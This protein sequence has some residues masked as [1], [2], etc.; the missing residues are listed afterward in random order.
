MVRVGVGVVF[1]VWG[2]EFGV[3]S[4]GLNLGLVRVRARLVLGLGLGLG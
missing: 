2:L 3:W 4:L 1:L